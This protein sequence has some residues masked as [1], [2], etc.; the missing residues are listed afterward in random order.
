MHR[1]R[2]I[3]QQ[4]FDQRLPAEPAGQIRAPRLFKQIPGAGTIDQ[5]L[6]H[7]L[8]EFLDGGLIDQRF[9]D[10]ETAIVE[11]PRRHFSRS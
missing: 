1:H 5:Q 4:R 6:V 7:R 2:I 3:G 9:R 11:T 10:H 8:F